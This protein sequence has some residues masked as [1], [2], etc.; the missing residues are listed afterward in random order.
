MKR[1][2]FTVINISALVLGALLWLIAELAPEA[3]GGFNLAWAGFIVTI[4]WAISFTVRVFFEE[5]TVMKKSWAILAGV[6]LVG[7]VGCLIGA[8]TMPDKLILPIICVAVSVA[9]L[10]GAL[11]L[12]G[13]KWDEGDNQ[14]PGYKTYHERK[15]EEEAQKLAEQ[16]T[17]E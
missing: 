8:I 12:G 7:A 14:K 6:F 1:H 4:I 11:V 13:K 2:I 9:L 10:V 15:A 3:M 17:E 5:Q 16:K